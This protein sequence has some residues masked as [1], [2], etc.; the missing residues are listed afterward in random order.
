MAARAPL[1]VLVAFG[2]VAGCVAESKW[3]VSPRVP[4]SELTAGPML[5]ECLPEF[6]SDTTDVKCALPLELICGNNPCLNYN[7]SVRELERLV[8]QAGHSG[9]SSADIGDCGEFRYV[10]R[11]DGYSGETLYFD[12]AGT[13]VAA[14][15]WS[16][17]NSN[18]F[19]FG[20]RIRCA[21]V[22]QPN[23]PFK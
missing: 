2:F 15:S 3:P 10:A 1:L 19:P 18:G 9:E 20:R 17:V 6:A 5:N 16:D 4:I 14:V 12:K 11:G 23:H 8:R 21:H 7:Q 13:L 22:R